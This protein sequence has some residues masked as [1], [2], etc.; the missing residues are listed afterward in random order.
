VFFFFFFKKLINILSEKLL[1]KLIDEKFVG[2]TKA[3][4]SGSL[5]RLFYC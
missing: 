3:T 2:V 5:I 1:Q 4:S